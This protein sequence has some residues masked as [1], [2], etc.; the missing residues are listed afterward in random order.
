MSKIKNLNYVNDT[1]CRVKQRDNRVKYSMADNKEHLMVIRVSDEL[2]FH[3]W[4][5]IE[6]SK[7]ILGS[8]INKKT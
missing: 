3:E 8:D 5:L 1:V 7:L 6:G 4:N 2:Y